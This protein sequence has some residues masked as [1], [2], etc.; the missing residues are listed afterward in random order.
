M[1]RFKLL[2]IQRELVYTNPNKHL[3]HRKI[4]NNDIISILQYNKNIKMVIK[5]LQILN[6][7]QYKLMER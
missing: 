6:N 3:Q 2:N 7:I 5:D 4:L 1:L